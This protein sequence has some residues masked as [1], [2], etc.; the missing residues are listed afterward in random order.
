MSRGPGR[1]ERPM[2]DPGDPV[3][4]AQAVFDQ[5]KEILDR[6]DRRLAELDVPLHQRG[7][8]VM[9][10]PPDNPLPRLDCGL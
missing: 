8:G 4:R 1:I 5:L 6:L 9:E 3:D 10:E 2:T 7:F